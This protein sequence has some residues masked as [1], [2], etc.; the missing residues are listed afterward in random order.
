MKNHSEAKKEKC[1]ININREQIKKNNYALIKNNNKKGLRNNSKPQKTKLIKRI[2]NEDISN[3]QI[4]K[5]HTKNNSMVFFKNI[6]KF[7]NQHPHRKDIKTEY[8]LYQ[9]E[10]QSLI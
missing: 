7:K 9:K 3:S 5:K 2:N 4:E 6:N 10:L 8:S 1:K